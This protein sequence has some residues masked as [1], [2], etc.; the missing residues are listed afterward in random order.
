[1]ENEKKGKK[2]LEI[3]LIILVVLSF[4]LIPLLN[5]YRQK[6]ISLNRTQFVNR[7]NVRNGTIDI[8]SYNNGI[9]RSISSKFIS[10]S[11]RNFE[12]TE[13]DVK[14]GLSLT[15]DNDVF[16]YGFNNYFRF[17]KTNY[18]T[19]TSIN[20]IYALEYYIIF[21]S[22][23][24]YS[25][26]LGYYDIRE[27]SDDIGNYISY[28]PISKQEF[29]NAGILPDYNVLNFSYY[30]QLSF[31]TFEQDRLGSQLLYNLISLNTNYQV[32]SNLYSYVVD[33]SKLTF[34]NIEQD[35]IT[36]MINDIKS[37]SYLDGYYTGFDDG[38][39]GGTPSVFTLL[40]K[41]ASAISSFLNIE[42][43]PNISMWLLISIPLSISIMIIL[44]RLLRGG[45]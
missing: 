38:Q 11:D 10:Y 13:D 25:F 39:A 24:S 21:N 30:N 33:S 23:K 32:S 37:S 42:V 34:V 8:V 15:G 4:V 40:S 45:S 2:V 27:D 6:S 16:G 35:T 20:N 3:I 43:L 12:F 14:S 36:D 7:Q 28:F 31:E 29:S 5:Q 9:V 18:S 26:K 19:I 1:M 44:L 41:A 17:V 22:S